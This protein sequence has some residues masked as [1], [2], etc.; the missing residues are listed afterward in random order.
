MQV[1]TYTVHLVNLSFDSLLILVVYHHTIQLSF[2]NIYSFHYRDFY[3]ST[4]S[5]PRTSCSKCTAQIGGDTDRDPFQYC[6]WSLINVLW[7]HHFVTF[8]INDR[9][10]QKCIYILYNITKL[11]P[12]MYSITSSSN[13]YNCRNKYIMTAQQN[14]K[15]K[16]KADIELLFFSNTTILAAICLLHPEQKLI[17]TCLLQYYIYSYL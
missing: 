7:L 3:N 2:V 13:S 17:Q 1:L 10:F 8:P 12:Y 5:S 9:Q 16:Q 14:D 6:Q 4:H 15:Y 11:M